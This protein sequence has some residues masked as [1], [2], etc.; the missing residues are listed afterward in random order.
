DLTDE[1][2]SRSLT[3]M[4][5]EV[6]NG[7]FRVLW[8]GAPEALPLD[9]WRLS[10]GVAYATSRNGPPEVTDLLP[11]SPSSATRA[12]ASSIRLAERGDTA[13]L[14]RLLAPMAVRYIVVPVELTTGLEE[15]GRYP[16]PPDLARALVS[17]I[18][19]RLL[20][21]D[22]GMTV[23][24]NTAWGPGRAALPERLTGPVPTS[25]GSG[26]DLGGGTPVLADGGPVRFTGTVP[27]NSTVLVAE[28]PSSRWALTVEGESAD[29]QRGYGVANVFRASEGGSARLRYRTPIL[30]YG[31]ILVQV[32]LWAMALRSL[33]RLRRRALDLEA[34]R[35]ATPAMA[36]TG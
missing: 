19:L 28:A 32:G 35:P 7:D 29:R 13:R 31:L 2:V 5:P 4:A 15:V 30:R 9:G 22:P 16:V 17:Q 20:P 33:L 12:I 21:S 34:P 23:Y 24:E 11:G 14:G 8:L 27:P 1:E 10:D 36:G 26:V 3:W 18:D 25:L 6:R